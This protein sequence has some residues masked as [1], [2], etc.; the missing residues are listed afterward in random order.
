[1]TSVTNQNETPTAPIF[2]N[3]SV[4]REDEE[5][6][7]FHK[8]T[9]QVTTSDLGDQSEASTI[10]DR[11]TISDATKAV[12]QTTISDVPKPLVPNNRFERESEENLDKDQGLFGSMIF[13]KETSSITENFYQITNKESQF[14]AG[15]GAVEAIIDSSPIITATSDELGYPEIGLGSTANAEELF[16]ATQESVTKQNKLLT[17]FIPGSTQP[18]LIEPT[19]L[20]GV[21]SEIES[22]QRHQDIVTVTTTPAIGGAKSEYRDTSTLG[23]IRTDQSH[24]GLKANGKFAQDSVS[25]GA[26]TEYKDISTPEPREGLKVNERLGL[27][28]GIGGAIAEYKDRSTPGT[29]RT[30]QNHEGLKVNGKFAQDSVSEGAKTE[31][32][33]I[34]TP[35][36]RE[37]LKVNERL[38]SDSGIEEVIPEYKDRPT[39]GTIRTDQSLEDLKA[40]GKFTQ[41]SVSEGAKTEYRDIST[42]QPKEGL[43][44]NERLGSDSGIEGVKAEYKDRSTPGTI[45][46]DQ[47]H[48][49]LK[50]NGK[51]A[52]DSVSEG[53][54]TEYRDISTPQ[55]K[56]GL[57]VNEGLG[58]DSGIEDV[59]PEYKDRSTPETIRTDQSHVG[60]NANGKFARDSVS[61]GA[62]PKEVIT[63]QIPISNTTKSVTASYRPQREFEGYIQDNSPDLSTAT[64]PIQISVKPEKSNGSDEDK[65]DLNA[66]DSFAVETIIRPPDPTVNKDGFRKDPDQT[67]TFVCKSAGQFPDQ[68]NCSVYHI[69]MDIYIQILHIPASCPPGTLYDRNLQN[70]TKR[71]VECSDDNTLQCTTSGVFAHPTDCNRY[72]KCFWRSLH[73]K[74]SLWQFKCPPRM[75]YDQERRKCVNA[76][77]AATLE[78]GGLSQDSAESPFYC[79]ENGRFPM[80]YN[81]D[82]YYDCKEKKGAFQTKAKFCSPGKLFDT[83]LGRCRRSDLVFCPYEYD[84]GVDGDGNNSAELN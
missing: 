35:E 78:C 20:I 57:K 24:V 72:Y 79:T 61:E 60:L 12:V 18:S 34:S 83:E 69:C 11:T 42:P 63:E 81:C 39:P 74:F 52:Q 10:Q 58:S 6:A 71:P 33:D 67:N 13:E 50:A 29:I 48:E 75:R 44:V 53:A 77:T 26:K 17:E 84:N 4:Q 47:S 56:E 5:I 70:C 27:D 43:K 30:D 3:N 73:K 22:P 59:I 65:T 21:N 1:M 54:K 16:G 2:D 64:N 80:E 49:G 9:Q 7:H 41:D 62:V 46:T 37:G 55:P 51:F 23:A 8:L 32:R 36:P 25:E 28:S 40:N 76:P 66:E 31:Y 19:K 68:K 15:N 14:S 82:G 45:R 38:G